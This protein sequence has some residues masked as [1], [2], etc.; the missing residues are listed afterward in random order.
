MAKAT[1]L[2]MA[3]ARKRPP[4]SDRQRAYWTYRAYRAARRRS[5]DDALAAISAYPDLHKYF[6]P[7]G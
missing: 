2:T 1:R 3:A 4:V 5:C 7:G 6:D